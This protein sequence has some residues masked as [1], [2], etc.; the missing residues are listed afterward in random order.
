MTEQQFRTWL[1]DPRRRPLVMGVLN[2][3]PDSF[4]DGGLFASAA[5]AIERAQALCDEGAHI[6]DIGGESSRPGAPRISAAQQ[7][8]RIL[9][10]FEAIKGRLPCVLSVDTTRAE[11]ARTAL[12]NGAT[13]VN[14]ISA[15]LDDPALLSLAGKRNTPLILMHMCGQ[16]AD[17]QRDPHYEDVTAEVSRFLAQRLSAAV[18]A[19]VAAENVMLDPGIGF[20]KTTEHNL[21]L[22][23]DLPR[24]RELGRPLVVG[25]SRKRFIGAITGDAEP[26]QRIM[27][28]AASVAWC[29][30]NG[31]DVV[32]VHDVGAMAKVVR[33]IEAIRSA[34]V[35]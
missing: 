13:I 9:P 4:S 33:M 8:N 23:R 17:M 18:A 24:L 31:T 3:T 34:S 25:T 19:G 35:P 2:V 28:T 15:G 1:K 22:L 30:A 5:A 20:G 27:G 7:I 29:V 6:I 11:V 16:P 10:V 21:Q 32:R 26:S 14:D 12:E